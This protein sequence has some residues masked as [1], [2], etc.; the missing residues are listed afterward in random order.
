MSGPDVALR[1][2]RGSDL[3]IFFEYQADEGASYA[4]A[5]ASRDR[6]AFDAHWARIMA[7][8]T[9]AIR[10]VVWDGQAAGN[11]L[12]FE[13][14]GMREVGYW[15]GREY[16]GKGIATKALAAFLREFEVRPLHGL[17]ASDN[18]GSVRVLEKCGFER[19][20]AKRMFDDTRGEELEELL[21]ELR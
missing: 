18:L 17:V 8:D 20:S 9:V 7:D 2:V 10:T 15:I 1:E 4:A 13:R 3:P 11:V 21:L 14:D 19:I 16:W 12:S 6:E 5:V